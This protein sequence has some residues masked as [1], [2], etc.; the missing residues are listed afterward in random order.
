MVTDEASST[1]DYRV[2]VARSGGWWAITVPTLDG[3]FSQSKRLDQVEDSAREAISLMLDVD[4]GDVGALDIIVTPPPIVANLLGALEELT[5]VAEEA[6]RAAAATRRE[7]VELLRAEGL[8]LRDVGALIG[9]S[10]QRVSQ[11][12]AS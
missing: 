7:V 9:V 12:L 3:V 11:L 6:T 5:A 8:P 10:H 1:N 2:E 4:A